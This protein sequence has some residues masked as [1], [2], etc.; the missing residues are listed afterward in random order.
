MRVD[1]FVPIDHF[2][3]IIT[4]EDGGLRKLPNVVLRDTEIWFL[5]FPMKLR[6]YIDLA[7][8]L[9]WQPSDK[10]LNWDGKNV[11]DGEVTLSSSDLLKIPDLISKAEVQSSLLTIGMKNQAPTEQ[12]ARHHEY[13]VAIRPFE[14]DKWLV[15]GESIGGG[16]AELGGSIALSSE[17]L[18]QRENWESHCVLAGCD[19]VVPIL[20][21]KDKRDDNIVDDIIYQ[22]KQAKI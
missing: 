22:Y 10:R 3:L 16:F 4:F 15:F 5:A 13:F 9:K 7:D 18:I 8:G 21:S 19:W 1:K 12:D 6:S 2:N 17:E 14:S 20:K 11:W